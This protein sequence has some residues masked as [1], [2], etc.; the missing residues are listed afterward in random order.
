MLETSNAIDKLETNRNNF[1]NLQCFNSWELGA[2]PSA[3][4]DIT[5]SREPHSLHSLLSP[6]CWWC[7]FLPQR[8]TSAPWGPELRLWQVNE[9]GT[10]FWIQTDWVRPKAAQSLSV[11]VSQPHLWSLNRQTIYHS[12]RIKAVTLRNSLLG[13]NNDSFN[14]LVHLKGIVVR[15]FG[16]LLNIPFLNP[17]IFP[18]LFW[19]SFTDY[20]AFLPRAD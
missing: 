14:I 7:H 8:K 5:R 15:D 11:L 20:L 16:S 19:N 4:D 9:G 17:G 10:Y 1:F 2:S 13:K 6:R 3:A 18:K 12:R